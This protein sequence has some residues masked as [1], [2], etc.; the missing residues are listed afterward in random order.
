MEATSC[1]ALDVGDVARH[2]DTDLDCGLDEA[3]ARNRLERFG[4]NEIDS[5]AAPRVWRV[6]LSQFRNPLIYVLLGSAA[7][8]LIIGHGVDAAVILG[9]V[10]VNALIGFIQ[11]W[12]AGIAVKMI[13]GDH[14]RTAEAIATQVGLRPGN[15][16][17]LLVMTGR[18]LATCAEDE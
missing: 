8:T 1:H 12:R 13:T 6:L 7:V 5:A 11:E 17:H 9:V 10:A 14:Q 18:D 2:L 16:Q 15:G 3:T 4:A